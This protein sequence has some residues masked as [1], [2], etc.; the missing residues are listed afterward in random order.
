MDSKTLGSVTLSVVLTLSPLCP[1]SLFF[2]QQIF[3]QAAATMQ[4][5][6]PPSMVVYEV[7]LEGL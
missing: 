6:T 3:S 1:I 2:W 7:L 5:P 4:P